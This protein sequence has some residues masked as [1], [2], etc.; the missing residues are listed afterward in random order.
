MPALPGIDGGGCTV[1]AYCR[2]GLGESGAS[3]YPFF[4]RSCL[5]TPFSNV[6]PRGHS[7]VG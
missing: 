4:G 5:L 3:L 1:R 7:E 6:C 2:A